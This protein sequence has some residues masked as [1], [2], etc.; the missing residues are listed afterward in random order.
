MHIIRRKRLLLLLLAGAVLAAAV[1]LVRSAAERG[2]QGAQS[3]PAASSGAVSGAGAAYKAI[4]YDNGSAALSFALDG[5]GK[6]YW[7][8]DKDFPL[9]QEDLT[10]MA[11]T[12][13]ALKPQ[14]TL[15]DPEPLESYGLDDPARTLS[16]TAVNGQLT[17]LALGNATTDGNSYYMLMN[18]SETPV[19][20]ISGELVRQMS[21]G[22]YEMC[23]LPELPA[24]GEERL[25]SVT[26]EGSASTVLSAFR[27]QARPD[28]SAPGGEEGETIWRCNGADVTGSAR[29]QS[30]LAQL[31]E[32]KLDACVDYRPSDGA[33]ALCGFDAPD[34]VI[35]ADYT[36]DG[37]A[38]KTLRLTVG[39]Q[40]LGGGGRYVRLDDD[41]TIYRMA[42]TQ[43]DVLLAVAANGLEA[44]PPSAD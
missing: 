29:V 9:D 1:F 25:R 23:L 7:T 42:D 27:P 12:L 20:I 38:D 2:R 19:F 30:V 35:T 21:V 40:V 39:R 24:L 4:S 36:G 5:E 17:T 13:S 16:A 15:T 28:G 41:A 6:W 44:A 43:L 22:I 11:D 34:A 32:L 10:Q 14:Q 18:G 31:G 8:D 33:A 37:N 3:D 26:L